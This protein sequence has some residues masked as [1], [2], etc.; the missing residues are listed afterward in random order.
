VPGRRRR[1]RRARQASQEAFAFAA[2]AAAHAE[3]ART[4]ALAAADAADRAQY[5]AVEAKKAADAAFESAKV[6]VAAAIKADDLEKL[7]RQQDKDRLAEATEQGVLAAQEALTQEQQAL[8]AGGELAAWN[9]GLLWDTAEADRVDPATRALLTEAAAPGASTQTALDKGRRAAVA[10]IVTGGEWSKAAAQE[11]LAGG[12][13]EMRSWLAN[14]RRFAAGQD[15]RARV[16]NLIDTLPD[17][18]EKTAARTAL[19][20]DDAAVEQFLRTRDYPGKF[21]KDRQAIYKIIEVAQAGKQPLLKAA[22]EKALAVGTPAAAHEFLRDGQLPARAADERQEVYRVM[23]AGG[24]EVKAAGQVALSGPTSYIAYFLT[25]S[26]YQAAQRDLEQATHEAVVSKLIFEA[27]QYAQQALEDAARARKAAED[28]AGHAA[29]AGKAKQ[30]ADAAAREAQ[31]HKD[32]AQKSAEKA[33][34]SANQAA[35]SAQTARNAANSAQ[36]SASQ[37][38]RSAA[39][40]TAASQRAQSDAQNAYQAKLDAR[41]SADAAGKD[42][43]AADLAAKEAATIYT[44]K[45]REWEDRQRSTAPGSGPDGNGTAADSRKSWGCLAADPSAVSKQC[46]KVYTEFAGVLINPAKCSAPA[47]SGTAGCQMLNDLKSFVEENSELLL[48]ILQFV[49]MTCGVVPGAGEVCDGIDAAVS[50]ERGDWVGGF[51]SIGAMVPG[52]GW[53]A[54]FAKGVKNSDK[55]RSIKEIVESLAKSCKRSSSFVPGTRVLLAD[56]RTEEI[57]DVGVGDSVLATDPDSGLTATK[58]VTATIS[59]AGTKKIVDISIDADGET[60]TQTATVSATWNHPFWVPQLD[61]WVPAEALVAGLSLRSASGAPV[62]ITAV[63][64]RTETTSVHN[65]TVAG[66]HTYY[67]MAGNTPVLVHNCGGSIRVS[68]SAQDWGTKG[69]HMHVGKHEVRLFPDGN[70]GI[71]AEPIRLRSGTATAED[72]QKALD[73]IKGNPQLR[74]DLIEKSR[75]A[76]NSM[77]SGEWGMSTNRAAEMHFLIKALE[78]MG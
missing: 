65:L 20:G 60:G 76:M 71:G 16:W 6:A 37:A 9:R 47:N 62:Q 58:A 52:A 66:H 12:E 32:D 70:G 64:R 15:D 57:E 28:A 49:L 17:G 77:N 25:A 59:S 38:A 33:R 55:L 75:S 73:E 53:A 8:A 5:S 10:L 78:G 68:P 29:E 24:A 3:N 50:F 2:Q 51:L 46:L 13:I 42:A 23:D 63:S 35:Q 21:A 27:K 44:T 45:L 4:A 7:A 54:T 11:V 14:G 36:A 31:R 72:A 1:R 67:A 18:P 26:R 19:S 56:G 39:V 22:A 41:R 43:S 34:D 40:A 48:D 69:A 74:A 30:D 61:S